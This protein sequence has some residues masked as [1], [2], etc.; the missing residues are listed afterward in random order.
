MLKSIEV[1]VSTGEIIETQFTP[2][3]KAE[4]EKN[5]AA[6]IE[7]VP[8]PEPTKEQLLIELAALIEKVKALA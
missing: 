3:E 4:W 5:R 8:S 2:Q 1:N 7:P 6:Y